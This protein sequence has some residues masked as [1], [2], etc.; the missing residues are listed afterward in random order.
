MI[1]NTKF[2]AL[3]A[4]ALTVQTVAAFFAIDFQ[5]YRL[6]Y[7]YSGQNFF[8]NFDFFTGLDPTNGHVNYVGLEKANS[9]S[10]AGFMPDIPRNNTKVPPVYLGT[11]YT[12]IATNGRKSV[13]VS[14]N[15]KF[16]HALVITDILHMPAPV[17]GVWP[18][19]WMLGSAQEWPKAGEID[20]LEGVND[21]TTNS[22]TLHSTAG[23]QLVN[24]TMKG[25][26]ITS[27]CDVNASNQ[28]K[29]VG[30]SI[31]DLA[32]S[33]S[34]GKAFNDN[35]GGVFATLIDS[36]GIRIWF[37]ERHNIPMDIYLGI[38]NPPSVD[39]KTLPGA[40]STWSTPNAVFSNPKSN[41]DSH[42]KDM[43]IIFNTAFCG[44]WAGKAWNSSPTCSKL[45]STCEEYVSKNP[46]AFADAYWAIQSVKVYEP[47]N[48]ILLARNNTKKLR[49]SF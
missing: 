38:P 23:I 6:T 10:L 9:T 28:D 17:C 11:D 13:R 46:N 8:N 26:I 36:Q 31:S 32:S 16:N 45:A 15:Q 29:N 44:D 7:D 48:G 25:K 47:T 1:A 3:L 33:K 19:Y 39:G 24:E 42:F 5:T 41:F 43:Q 34:Y 4:N 37:F 21:A 49:Q 2:A 22:Y 18:A 14:S 40:N 30:C 12:N 20:I 35:Q 27:N